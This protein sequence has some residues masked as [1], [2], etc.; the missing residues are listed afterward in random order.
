MWWE[1]CEELNEH[2]IV[3]SKCI[4]GFT[5]TKGN[6][7][8]CGKISWMHC[9]YIV[10][11][12]YYPACLNFSTKLITQN[13]KQWYKHHLFAFHFTCFF[14]KAD[15]CDANVCNGNPIHL[16]GTVYLQYE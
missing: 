12:E 5:L 1:N 15:Q 3:C 8:C 14:V 10:S 9:A 13:V 4:D 11:S 6:K 16:I 7:S 2:E